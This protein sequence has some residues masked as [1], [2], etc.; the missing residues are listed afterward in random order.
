M[1][2]VDSREGRAAG[3]PVK[4]RVLMEG[5]LPFVS[6][7]MVR[8]KWDGWQCLHM[9]ARQQGAFTK[10][11]HMLWACTCRPPALPPTPPPP[12]TRVIPL[13]Q[14]IPIR[15]H[16]PPPHNLRR[17]LYPP[18]TTPLN[19]TC[20]RAPTH[21]HPSVRAQENLEVVERHLTQLNQ[22]HNQLLKQ[23]DVLKAELEVALAGYTPKAVI[24][25]GKRG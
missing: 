5:G 17:T 16:G 4:V 2:V 7:Q 13:S 8:G 10:D 9:S 15:L 19:P 11:P 18:T 6:D 23:Q 24:D 12:R 22:E 1:G 14:H 21:P 20:S 25:A 3:L